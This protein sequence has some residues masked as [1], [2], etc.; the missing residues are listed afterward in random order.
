MKSA[1]IPY[2]ITKSNT[3]E[4]LLVQNISG[5]KWIIPKGNIKKTVSPAI[6]S[7]IEAYEE[8]GVL[9]KILPFSIGAYMK[10]GE[11]IP[12]YMLAVD[13]ELKEYKEQKFR[14]RKWVDIITSEKL[15]NDYNL[16]Q[17]LKKANT[18]VE[19]EGVYFQFL[20]N[21]LANEM[22][23]TI[24]TL[25]ENKANL[26]RKNLKSKNRKVIIKR[27]KATLQIE[28]KSTLKN[29][30]RDELFK[31]VVD[32][33]LNNELQKNDIGS[34][35]ISKNNTKPKLKLKHSVMMFDINKASFENQ[36]LRLNNRISDFETA[37]R[38]SLV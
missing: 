7:A 5:S 1:I 21:A 28:L 17:L 15:I 11:D 8:A 6:S 9:G 13:T 12:V 2:R 37:C 22:Q 16:L 23:L 19:N 33:R 3:T 26:L 30:L 18:V 10:K 31:K 25:N 29:I 38:K 4:I 34:W 24:A 20:I 36:L 32:E 35:V 14:K 27:K